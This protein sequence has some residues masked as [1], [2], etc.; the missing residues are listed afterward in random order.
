MHAFRD[1]CEI[2]DGCALCDAR[3][4]RLELEVRRLR[5]RWRTRRNRRRWLICELARS[6][7]GFTLIEIMVVL[8]ILRILAA[9]LGRAVVSRFE[10]G[11]RKSTVMQ[12]REVSVSVLHHLIERGSCPTID[13]LVASKQLRRVPVDPWATKLDVRCPGSKDPDGIDVVSA[14]PD[15]SMGTGDDLA[16][17]DH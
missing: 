2:W 6:E 11:R 16:S 13:E 5:A 10:E 8:A 9:T 4:R 7:D 3:D 12:L 17:W 15:R 1:V 14:G